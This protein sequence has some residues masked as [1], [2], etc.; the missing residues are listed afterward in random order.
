MT[1][2]CAGLG[3]RGVIVGLGGIASPARGREVMV[4]EGVAQ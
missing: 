1:V 3:W 2:A 4:D